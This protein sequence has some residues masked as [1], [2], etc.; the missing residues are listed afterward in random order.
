MTRHKWLFAIGKEIHSPDGDSTTAPPSQASEHSEAKA[1]IDRNSNRG[2]IND[3]D[4][5]IDIELD[6][7][8]DDEDEEDKEIQPPM[9][10]VSRM[11]KVLAELI[12]TEQKYVKDLH[13]LVSTYLEPIKG[14]KYLSSHDL[15]VLYRNVDE[16]VTFQKKFLRILEECL[17][18]DPGFNSY[19]SIS[20]FQVGN[21]VHGRF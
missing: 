13:F 4:I 1:K 19:T 3:V 20:Q 16:I 9:S 2:L 18:A 11:K 10:N 21:V 6:V 8:D 14:E 5:G 15:E 7:E 17:E 12:E